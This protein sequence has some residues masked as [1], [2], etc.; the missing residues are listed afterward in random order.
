[1]IRAP[2]D[3]PL[4][5]IERLR[6]LS[7]MWAAA[8]TSSVARLGRLVIN[9]GGFFARIAETQ[10]TTTATLEKFAR[11]FIDPFNWGGAD[12]GAEGVPEEARVFAHM[13]GVSTPGAGGSPDNGT[14]GIGADDG[15]GAH[16][17]SGAAQGFALTNPGPGKARDQRE[18]AA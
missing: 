18:E 13:M 16:P 4:S 17:S 7:E 9:D 2:M 3:T 10:S 1:M 5:P 8:T 14:G 6:H 15:E 12:T 11:F